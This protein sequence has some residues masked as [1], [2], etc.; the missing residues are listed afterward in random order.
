MASYNPKTLEDALLGAL[1]TELG[2]L[3]KTLETHQGDW[4]TDL[5][6]RAW[7]FPAVLLRLQQSRG[8]Q[9]TLR[10]CDLTLDFT[11][12]VVVRDL[13]GEDQ[14]RR[15]ET[16]AYQLLEGVRKA[17]WLQDLGLEL[18]P[19]QLLREEPV[20]NNQEFSV[21]A[22]DYRTGLVADF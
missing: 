17:L 21:Y 6:Q 5:K 9:V 13:R 7:R 15:G 11:V 19:C 10:S 4:R 18:L 12:L 3:V 16:G 14:G 2:S 22:A 1:Q 8:A 20:L